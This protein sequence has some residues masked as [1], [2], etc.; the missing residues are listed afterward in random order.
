[1]KKTGYNYQTYIALSRIKIVYSDNS[2]SLSSPGTVYEPG[3]SINLNPG[4]HMF[5]KV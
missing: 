5:A 4:C 2:T 1:M 3:Q